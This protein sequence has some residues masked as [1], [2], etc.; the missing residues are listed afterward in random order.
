MKSGP[1]II[2]EDDHDDKDILEEGSNIFT[3]HFTTRQT[4]KRKKA[5]A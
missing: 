5:N 2:I 3:I 4:S 1:I